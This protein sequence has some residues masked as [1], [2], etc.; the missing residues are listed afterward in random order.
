MVHAIEYGKPIAA[1][2]SQ[3]TGMLFKQGVIF[4]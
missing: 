3:V 2:G 1:T 4:E